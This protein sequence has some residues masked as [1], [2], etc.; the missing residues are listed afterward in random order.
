[1]ERADVVI[2]GGGPVGAAMA[3]A[4]D[5]AGLDVRLVDPAPRADARLRPVAL[6]HGSRLILETLGAWGSF[7]ATPIEH[8]HVSQARG[9]GRTMMHAAEL[10]VPALGHVCNLPA[11]AAALARRV[12]AI[13]TP[14]RIE[15]RVTAWE[16]HGERV[17]AVVEGPEGERE[18]SAHLVALA[19]G[20]RTAG[21]DLAWR[22]YGQTAIA[23]V[24]QAAHAAPHTAWERFTD[25][26]PL[27]LLPFE[28]AGTP[29]LALVWTVRTERAAALA[30]APEPAF[31][32]ELGRRFGGRVGRFVAVRERETYP[33]ALRYR[34]SA[35]VAPRVVAIGNAAQTLH[36]VA[37]QGLNLG[38][39]DAF[40][41]AAAIRA[42][43]DAPGSDAV[44]AAFDRARR[45]DRMASVSIT[46]GLVRVFGT[47]LP[48]AGLARG[49]GLA[50]LDAVPA[51]RR[52]FAR[53][54]MLGLRGLP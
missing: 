41:L 9:F 27:A 21:A 19:D 34:R 30:E 53:R 18:I 11:L 5:G 54:M 3:A 31:L 7:E 24:V 52:V 26:G 15:G 40:E 16:P 45:A 6:A 25:E 42:A 28:S 20:G 1:M 44:L 36:P 13:A 35:L 12:A 8:I 37:G 14:V 33:L 39:R 22:D 32:E 49:L 48:G 10:G 46:D 38:L 17:L 23:A 2:A 51:A 29:H 43:P 4:L 47:T 50:A